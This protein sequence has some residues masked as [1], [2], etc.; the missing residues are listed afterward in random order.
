[1]AKTPSKDDDEPKTKP[2]KPAEPKKDEAPAD[3]PVNTAQEPYPTGNPP[4]PEDEFEKMHG[5]RRT[6]KKE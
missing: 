4:D 1:M 6:P 3:A 5:F 2:T